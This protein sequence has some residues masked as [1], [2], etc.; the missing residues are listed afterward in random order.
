[1]TLLRYLLI[2]Q[3]L[4]LSLACPARAAEDLQSVL[5]GIREKYAELPGLSVPYT[6]EVITRSLSM[7]G[8][9]VEGDQA[10]GKIYFKPPYLLRLE[11]HEPRAETL[12]STGETIWW[13][14]PEEKLAYRYPSEN[15]GK[16]L[17]LLGDIFA[18]LADVKDRFRVSM[19]TPE[20][21][22]P[23]RI[24]LSPVPPWE[25]IEQVV[26][27]V[28]RGNEIRGLD[29]HNRLGTITRFTLGDMTVQEDLHDDLFRFT[30]PEDVEVI[31]KTSSEAF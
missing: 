16:E 17:K 7:L 1:M 25:E 11:Q 28:N 3:I 13:Y 14:I 30:V 15:F 31:R 12:L 4:V 8:E 9:K 26:I 10:S 24:A 22:G 27:T 29:I 5:S 23:C 20:Q 6:R 2:I 21:Q 18:G 19:S